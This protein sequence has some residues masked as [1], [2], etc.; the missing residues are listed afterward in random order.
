MELDIKNGLLKIGN[1]NFDCKFSKEDVINLSL[2]YKTIEGLKI[3]DIEN[4]TITDIDLGENVLTFSF[5][6][7]KL[8]SINI[9][10]GYLYNFD[11]FIITEAERKVIQRKI[12]SIGG[13]KKYSWGK[14]ELNDDSKGGVVSILIS[15][16]C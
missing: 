15:Y 2:T 11:P 12:N 14:V 7:K 13:E 5:K 3:G 16:N 1:V 8:S 6:D 4:F 10:V 9:T